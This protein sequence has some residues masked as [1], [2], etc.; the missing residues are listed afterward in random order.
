[1]PMINQALTKPNILRYINLL[2]RV[3][4]EPNAVFIWQPSVG[5]G[6]QT[7]ILW[8]S[9]QF[10]NNYFYCWWHIPLC[11][12]LYWSCFLPLPLPLPPREAVL[13]HNK[14]AS[15]PRAKVQAK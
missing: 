4:R 8:D 11:L 6:R 7:S 1:M 15:S 9:K 3:I 10:Q 14:A 2:W 12:L 5:E 13:N